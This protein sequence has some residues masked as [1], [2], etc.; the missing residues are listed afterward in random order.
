MTPQQYIE[1]LD[2]EIESCRSIVSDKRYPDDVRTWQYGRLNGL[3]DSK[4]HFYM[5]C[6][7]NN[8]MKPSGENAVA[9]T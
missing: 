2:K 6:A 1:Y 4:N 3:W 8:L 9:T 7:L 5:F